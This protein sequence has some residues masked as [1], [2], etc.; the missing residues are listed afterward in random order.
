M[1]LTVSILSPDALPLRLVST[2]PARYAG[3][4]DVVAEIVVQIEQR[5]RMARVED[6]GQVSA[7]REGV[8]EH[9]AKLVVNDHALLGLPALRHVPVLV[10]GK[11]HTDLVMIDR[12]DD[13]I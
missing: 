2:V 8:H 9:L 13:Y 7:D 4:V 5:A 11:V 3:G 1:L 6:C 12:D 10:L